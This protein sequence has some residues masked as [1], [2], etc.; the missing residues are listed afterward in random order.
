MSESMRV[1]CVEA[2]DPRD[3]HDLD[4]YCEDERL[5]LR[6]VGTNVQ[7]VNLRSAYRVTY[8]DAR[9]VLGTCA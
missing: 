9:D 7:V 3:H 5:A 6:R 4:I 8:D 1:Q 2:V